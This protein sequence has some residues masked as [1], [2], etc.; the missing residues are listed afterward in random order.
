VVVDDAP[1]HRGAAKDK[2]KASVRRVLC[3]RELPAACGNGV[4]FAQG[5]NF[6]VCEGERAHLVARIVILL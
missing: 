5:F 2:R 4:E 3:A 1:A 6:K